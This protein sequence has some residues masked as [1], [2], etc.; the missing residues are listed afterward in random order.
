MRP[1]VSDCEVPDWVL[2]G[3]IHYDGFIGASAGV[4]RGGALW[5]GPGLAGPRLIDSDGI[6]K[7]SSGCR[8]L[9]DYEFA[10]DRQR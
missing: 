8:S 9:S 3:D 6:A 7:G 1:A 2:G 5:Q 4:R 10:M